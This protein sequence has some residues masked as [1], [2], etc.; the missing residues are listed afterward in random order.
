MAI[1]SGET[2]EAERLW[3][4]ALLIDDTVHSIGNINQAQ[5]YYEIGTVLRPAHRLLPTE[6]YLDARIVELPDGELPDDPGN[7]VSTFTITALGKVRPRAP[8]IPSRDRITPAQTEDDI[9]AALLSEEPVVKPEPAVTVSQR[10]NLLGDSL[11]LEQPHL[12]SD[13]FSWWDDGSVS[14][15]TVVYQAGEHAVEHARAQQQKRFYRLLGRAM[16]GRTPSV[17]D[18]AAMVR[19]AS[20]VIGSARQQ[21]SGALRTDDLRRLAP[22]VVTHTDL[23]NLPVSHVSY[24]RRTGL[25]PDPRLPFISGEEYASMWLDTNED[26]ENQRLDLSLYIDR[27]HNN[28]DVNPA[29]YAAI[30]KPD[31]TGAEVPLGIK[32]VKWSLQIR[33]NTD[34]IE[35]A[36]QTPAEANE[37]LEPMRQA[38]QAN[39]DKAAIFKSKE[40]QARNALAETKAK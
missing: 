14:T 25:V 26:D 24:D 34:R 35:T 2:I 3:Q 33:G 11:E 30:L 20:L 32:V 18:L 28:P 40:W 19:H 13:I 7:P 5:N 31:I 12:G 37:L 23:P 15:H 4:S 21:Q 1:T 9:I 10:S 8:L 39:A 6:H 27:L 36:A 17:V 16:D 22:N 29:D 38:A